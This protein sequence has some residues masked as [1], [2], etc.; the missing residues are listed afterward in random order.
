MH[1]SLLS[2]VT[3]LPLAGALAILLTRNAGEAADR[4][5]RW[6][7]LWTSLL[8]LAL[9]VVIWSEFDPLQAGPQFEQQLMWM[10]SFG[11]SYHAGLDGIS[12]VFVLLT[13]FLT[14]LSI[15]AAWRSVNGR[16]CDF[17][18]AMLLLET[19][20][21]GLFSALDLV[22]FYVFYEATLIPAS[23]MIGVWGGPKRIWASLQF[24]LFTF[25][26]SLFMLV[27]LVAMWSAA[28]TTDIPFLAQTHFSPEM[29]CWLLMG[30]VLAFGVKLPLFP[31]HAW[32]PDAYTEAPTAASAMLSGVLSKTGA[33]GLLRFG[34]L[35]F[36]DAV[37]RFAPYILPLGVIAIVY[38]AFVAFAQKDAKRVIAYSSFSHM[39]M[40][41]VG[42]FTLNPEGVDGAI[43]QMLSHGVVIAALFFC[44]AAIAWRAET[45]D[46]SALG[47]VAM[48][49]P[50][51]ATLAM[52]FTMANV[53][54]P[55]TGSF[56]GELLILMG[57]V[58]VSLWLALLAGTT[59][60]MGAV[61]MLVLYREVLFGHV[62]GAVGL[63]RDLTAAEI[64]VLAPLAIVTLWMGVHPG[65]FTR[66]FDP[67][68][69]HMLSSD[70]GPAT[71]SAAHASVELAAR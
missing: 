69:T 15:G 53:G 7:A 70:G 59:M 68:I 24:F 67:A 52:L 29:Q 51:L 19:A 8:V 64:A 25:G 32:L 62:R 13:A 42:L 30:F 9:S 3:Y 47:G 17:M 18:A 45:R 27:A 63:L 23:L 26:G 49:M 5:A 22:L 34:V 4:A 2:L 61:Y 38:A 58:H 33:Y 60:I 10:P 1:P 65:S 14:P 66:L 21:M 39:G 12:L 71:A 36:P 20:L 48:R 35:M 44:V 40:I 28:G 43:Y 37:H 46:M 57:A 54:L 11:V 50:A 6:I 55:G 31:L 41:A 16:A 56:V